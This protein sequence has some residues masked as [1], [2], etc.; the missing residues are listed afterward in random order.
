MIGVKKKIIFEVISYL[1]TEYRKGGDKECCYPFY[2]QII[3]GVPFD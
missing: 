3:T 2:S 1:F